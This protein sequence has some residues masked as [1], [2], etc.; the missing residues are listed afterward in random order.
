MEFSEGAYYLQDL[1][2]SIWALAKAPSWKKRKGLC[3]EEGDFPPD[4]FP[5]TSFS[6]TKIMQK[7]MSMG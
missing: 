3:T 5:E 4:S 7:S 1:L 2:L 6:D